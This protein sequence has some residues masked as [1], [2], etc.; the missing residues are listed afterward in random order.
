[1]QS[2]GYRDHTKLKRDVFTWNNLLHIGENNLLKTTFLFGHLFYETPGALTKTEFDADPKKARPGTGAFP[3]AE[4]ANTSIGQTMFLAGTSYTQH[5]SSNFQNR[6]T[7]Y[8]MFTE[9]RNPALRN[10][11][12]S[13][14]P[15]T[16]A[17]T[18][19]KFNRLV[20]TVLFNFDFGGEIQRGFTSAS[21]YKNV[22]GNADSLRT[23]DEINNRQQF[24]FSQL[25]LELNNWTIIAGA[26]WNALH[27]KFQRFSPASFGKQNRTFNNETAPRLSILKKLGEI[28]IYASVARGFSPPTTSEL[29]PTG[30]AINLGLNAEEGVN[31]E[32]GLKATIFKKLYVDIN[33][34]IFSLKNTIVLRRDAGG[35]DFYLNAG[36][37]KQHGI[38]TFITYPLFYNSPKFKNCVMWLSDTWHNF[39]YK[40]FKQLAN[41]FTG[42]QVPSVAPHTV[43]SGVDV[44]MNNGLLGTITYFYSDKIPLND[45]NTEYAKS[46]HLIG[47]KIGFQKCLPAGQAGY[48]NKLGIKMFGGVENLLNEIYSLGN[49]INGFGG[50]YYNPAARRNFYAGISFQFVTKRNLNILPQ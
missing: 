42:K 40:N 35:G 6:T 44:A 28:N 21:I 41:D 24:L 10:Y 15:H 33:T 32:T 20:N 11:G 25:S 50:R 43:S 39:H 4:A 46:Y 27:V 45:G 1:M 19:F 47:A 17:R 37:T 30:G 9:L 29:L 36:S 7:L 23:F 34:F 18:V 5:I 8:G 49:D 22:N 3:G 13:A 26:S 38:E 14:E 16:G 12:K 2:D 48:K 31:Y